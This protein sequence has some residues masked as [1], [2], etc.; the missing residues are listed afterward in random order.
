MAVGAEWVGLF[1]PRLFGDP[2]KGPTQSEECGKRELSSPFFSSYSFFLS[3]DLR[4]W[5]H[6]RSS[7]WGKV[8]S[9]QMHPEDF[10]DQGARVVVT[11]SG[12]SGAPRPWT[13][14]ER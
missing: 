14:T 11:C 4:V 6:P 13:E 7:T 12:V 1:Y 2:G 5:P 8:C 9:F 3:G 10:M